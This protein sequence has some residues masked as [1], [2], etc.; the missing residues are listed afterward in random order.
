MR[1]QKDGIIGG[2]F[3]LENPT[4]CPRQHSLLSKWTSD[5]RNTYFFHNARSAIRYVVSELDRQ[6]LWLPSYNCPAIEVSVRDVTKELRYYPL[7]Q[8]LDPEVG[9]LLNSVQAGD[10]VLGINFFG[11]SCGAKW[12]Q[13]RKLLRGVIW[14]EDCAQTL[15]T[16]RGHFGDLRIYSPGKVI[17]V[18]DGGVLVDVHGMLQAPNLEPETDEAF[19]KPSVMR[20]ADPDGRHHDSWYAAYREVESMMKPS[21]RRMSKV[22]RDILG[23]I[24]SRPILARR[25]EN[26]SYLHEELKDL[27]F[28]AS[29]TAEWTPLGFPVLTE[30]HEEL[31]HH[32]SRHRV[33]APRHWRGLTSPPDLFPWEHGLSRTLMTIPCDQRYGIGDMTRV[34]RLIREIC[35]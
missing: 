19:M 32:L 1:N 25:R 21:N 22:T 28:F 26:Y 2:L 8:Q 7:D 6:R 12:H 27:A 34:V 24:D 14:I 5:S 17:G 18:P 31:W 30:Q 13:L 20:A 4:A 3:A 16:G 29:D 33:F 11:N 15:D 10:V 9:F 35:P 23:M